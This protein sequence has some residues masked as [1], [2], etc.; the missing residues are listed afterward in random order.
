MVARESPAPLHVRWRAGR[1]RLIQSFKHFP[2][3]LI[4]RRRFYASPNLIYGSF[5]GFPHPLKDPPFFVSDVP[6]AHCPG[7]VA[8]IAIEYSTVIHDNEGVPSDALGS[9]TA[10]GRAE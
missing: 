8:V 5:L 6:E 9:G 1:H 4:Y 10:C 7:H 3:G 2:R